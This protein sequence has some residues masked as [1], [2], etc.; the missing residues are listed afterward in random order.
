MSRFQ[1]NHP[2]KFLGSGH[3]DDKVKKETETVELCEHNKYC[4]KRIKQGYNCLKPEGN[5]CGQVKKFYDSYGEAGNSLGVG[6]TDT[7]IR[8]YK[9]DQNPGIE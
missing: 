6:A 5:V 3:L 1:K 7:G 9:E 4:S 2:R 8:K